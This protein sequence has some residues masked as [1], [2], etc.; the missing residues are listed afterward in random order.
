MKRLN[1]DKRFISII[2][3]NWEHQTKIRLKGGHSI[4][5]FPAPEADNA[6]AEKGSTEA[7]P[8]GRIF[9]LEKL[10][11]YIPFIDKKPDAKK[12]AKKGGKGKKPE[13]EEEGEEGEEEDFRPRLQVSSLHRYNIF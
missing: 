9:G 7:G 12:P 13:A 2:N 11:I 5:S 3:R 4:A 10:G 8:Q 6:A 1:M